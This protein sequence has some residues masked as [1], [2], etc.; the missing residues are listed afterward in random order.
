MLPQKD[1]EPHYFF[2]KKLNASKPFNE[3]KDLGR[4]SGCTVGTKDSTME[5]HRPNIIISGRSPPL[6]CTLRTPKQKQT[7][8]SYYTVFLD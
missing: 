8:N 5:S 7:T 6:H 4:N 2:L 1:Y 3:S